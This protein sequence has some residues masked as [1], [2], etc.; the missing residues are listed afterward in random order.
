LCERELIPLLLLLRPT[1]D[2]S[3][4]IDRIERNLFRASHAGQVVP[5]TR[6]AEL[7]VELAH[8]DFHRRQAADRELRALGPAVLVYL[9]ALE[10]SE[11]TWEQ[12]QR[13]RHIQD[14]L[15]NASADT[16]E[17][18]ALW[19][20]GDERIWVTLL[21][22]SDAEKRHLALL[23]LMEIRPDVT[24]FDPYGDEVYRQKQLDQMRL[25]LTG[26]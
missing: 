5:R 6:L 2:F 4:A 10:E 25:V 8:R 11:L 14:C 18:V 24:S 3:D 19:L 13:I 12:R 7:V 26:R 15:A 23:Q 17:R 16:P 20:V 22:H 21:S 9:S 1:W